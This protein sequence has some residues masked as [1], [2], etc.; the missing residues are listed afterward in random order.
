MKSSIFTNRLQS[1]IN[2]ISGI[3]KIYI[4][5]QFRFIAYNQKLILLF[6]HFTDKIYKYYKLPK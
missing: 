1:Q 5:L 2:L 4:S 6:I 3:K